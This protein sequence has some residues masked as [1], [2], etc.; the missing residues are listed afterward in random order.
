MPNTLVE[1]MSVGLPI[2]CSNRGPMPEVLRDG[3][4]YFDPENYVSIAQAVETLINEESKRLKFSKRAQQLSQQYK[5]SRC[6]KET[7]TYLLDTYK[8]QKNPK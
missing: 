2:A 5:W 1:G 8:A 3:G 7:F 4:I 6:A